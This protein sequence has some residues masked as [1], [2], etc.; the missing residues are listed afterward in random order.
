MENQVPSSTSKP[1]AP[2][3]YSPYVPGPPGSALPPAT[4]YPAGLPAV[5]YSAQQPTT[6]PLHQPGNSAPIQYQPGRYPEP[7]NAA[8]VPWM[9]SPTPMPGCPPGLE[10][11]TQLDNIHILQ[12]FQPIER[13]INFE[14]NNRYDV[15]NQENQMVY[16]V[17]EDTDDYTRNA[18]KSLRPFVLRVTDA[19]GREVMTMQ[20]PFK[21]TVCCYCCC[22]NTR[23]EMEVQCPP[24][25][26]LGFIREQW[27]LCRALFSIQNEKREAVMSVQGPCCISCNCCSDAPF[28]VI[29]K[30]GV[31]TGSITR[32]W[33]G[34]LTASMDADHFEVDFPLS[35]DVKMK[36]LIFGACFLIDFMYFERSAQSHHQANTHHHH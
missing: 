25:V 2:P 9:P 1:D 24:G 3:A 18:Y 12:H 22:P 28:E 10:L 36:A 13:I 33:T 30:E 23:Q 4:S 20:R 17:S 14:A 15:R 34:I 32:K 19:L 11:L 8:S 31:S 27:Q 6:F 7:R 26:T 5:Y 21:C 29:T 35:L 16:V